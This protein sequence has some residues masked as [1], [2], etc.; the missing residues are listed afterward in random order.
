MEEKGSTT[1]DISDLIKL[2]HLAFS[3]RIEI[4]QYWVTVFSSC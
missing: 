2:T 3:A 4:Q 1:Q